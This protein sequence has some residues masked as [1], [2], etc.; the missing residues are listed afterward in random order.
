MTDE[1]NILITVAIPAF[2]HEKIIKFT[3]ESIKNSKWPDIEL[4]LIDDGSK[5]KTYEVATE[6]IEKNEFRFKRVIIKRQ[7]NQ[8]VCKTLNQLLL[9]SKGRYVA[10]LASDDLL[11][12]NSLQIR[13]EA[14]QQNMWADAVFSNSKIIDELGQ[15]TGELLHQKVRVNQ[16]LL[17][18]RRLQFFEILFAWPGCGPGLM[19]RNPGRKNIS[20][21]LFREDLPFEDVEFLLRT[22]MEGRLLYIPEILQSYRIVSNS[23]SHSNE[24][25]KTMREGH[26]AALRII[27]R[28]AR[29]LKKIAASLFWMRNLSMCSNWRIIQLAGRLLF[30]GCSR[31]FLS[32][33]R[34]ASLELPRQ[35]RPPH[36]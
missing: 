32:I 26:L 29:S 35:G 16:T 4:V 7:E 31:L 5:D 21:I 10:I 28:R 12:E 34:A 8:G 20:R 14:L 15:E 18:N 23:F 33:L 25:Q 17:Q 9:E 1:S 36:S 27:Q 6:W 22:S 30:G 13:A 24:N 3:L 11:Q 19:L 2:N